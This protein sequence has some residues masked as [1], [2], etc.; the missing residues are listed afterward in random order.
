M[1]TENKNIL[2]DSANPKAEQLAISKPQPETWF[3]LNDVNEFAKVGTWL[4]LNNRLPEWSD[5]LRNL[6]EI[7][8]SVKLEN[9]QLK[10][11]IHPSDIPDF[12]ECVEKVLSGNCQT[13]EGHVRVLTQASKNINQLKYLIKGIVSNGTVIG[14]KGMAS[15]VQ[16]PIES[17]DFS[18]KSQEQFNVL[19]ATMRQGVIFHSPNSMVGKMNPA[20]YTILGLHPS[21][22]ND[23]SKLQFFLENGQKL[24]VRDYPFLQA[25]KTGKAILGRTLQVENSAGRSR[26]IRFDSFPVKA[27]EEIAAYSIIEDI[28]AG[29]TSYDLLKQSEERLANLFKQSG[30]GMAF[31]SFGGNLLD[32]NNTFSRI[33]GYS[34][35]EL[36]QMNLEHLTHPNDLQQIEFELNRSATGKITSFNLE[37][38]LIHKNKEICWVSLSASLITT[39]SGKPYYLI[40]QFQDITER[41]LSE[42]KIFESQQKFITAFYGA[43]VGMAISDLNGKIIDANDAICKLL[44]FKKQEI[45]GKGINKITYAEDS[46]KD[47]VQEQNL[48]N[49]KING[50][51]IQKRYTHKSGKVI[52]GL[53]SVNLIRDAEGLP[54]NCIIQIQDMTEQVLSGEAIQKERQKFQHIF[55]FASIGMALIDTMGKI[56]DAN[57]TLCLILGYS[58]K[59]LQLQDLTKLA[60]PED[61]AHLKSQL[62]ELS[63]EKLSRTTIEIR[64]IHKNNNLVHSI[65]SA[66]RIVEPND[67]GVYLLAQIQ[68]INELKATQIKRLETESKFKHVVE[69]AQIGISIW[70]GQT[71]TYR[72][73]AFERFFN[74][75]GAKGNFDLK[76][77]NSLAHAGTRNKILETQ[78]KLQKGSS[79]AQKFI[80]KFGTPHAY[81]TFELNAKS[82]LLEGKL[83]RIVLVNDL[84]DNLRLE[85]ELRISQKILDQ[86]Q[87]FTKTGNWRWIVGTNDFFLSKSVYSILGIK[88]Q[89]NKSSLDQFINAVHPEDKKEVADAIKRCML[90]GGTFQIEHRV[91]Q[92]NGQTKWM[93]ERGTTVR[94]TSGDVIELF[95]VIREIT[96]EKKI[97][98]ELN[99]SKEQYQLLA[100]SGQELISLHTTDGKFLYASPSL[101]TLLGVPLSK[102]PK[103]TKLS[104]LVHSDDLNSFSQLITSALNQPQKEFIGRFRYKHKIGHFIPCEQSI[105]ALISDP[106]QA[107]TIRSLIRN[108]EGQISFE[109]QLK[110]TNYQFEIALSALN[111]ASQAKENF[112]SVMSHEIRTPLNSVIGLSHLLKRRNPRE[113]QIEIVETLKNSADNLMHLVN[114]ILDYNKIRSGKLKIENI[115]F[116]LSAILRQLLAAYKPLAQ[117]KEINLTIQIDSEIPD[118]VK[119]DSTRLNQIFTNLITNA[120]KFT[121]EGF[122]KVSAALKSLT[123]NQCNVDFIIEDSG[124]GIPKEYHQA[125]F[126][127]FQQSDVDISRKFGGTGL[128]LSIVKSLTELMSG[129]IEITSEP[130]VGSTFIVT[131]PFELPEHN[132]LAL[133]LPAKK[134]PKITQAKSNLHILYVEDVDS[135]RFLLEQILN[136]YQLKCTSVSSGKAALKLTAIKKFDLILMDLQMPILD[137]YA[138]TRKIKNQPNGVNTTTPIVAFTAEAFSAELKLKTTSEGIVYV[139]SKPFDPEKLIEKII[140][141]SASKQSPNPEFS[142]QFYQNLFSENENKFNEIKTAIKS[143]FLRFQKKI[144]HAWKAKDQDLI[145]TESHRIRPIARNLSFFKLTSILDKLRDVEIENLDYKFNLDEAIALVSIL[146][147]KLDSQ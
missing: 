25:I 50:Y 98:L 143:D 103:N 56:L 71:L 12:E 135:N 129:V 14:L 43:S 146:L 41:V 37:K 93:E 133:E 44:G 13:C 104:D 110:E 116:K 15:V 128:G 97:Q 20:A 1:P 42:K 84:T 46:D 55:Q 22:D 5:G 109:N 64:F 77:I 100:E 16:R 75:A 99:Q 67:G 113:D 89:G 18:Q 132:K 53:L 17:L 76:T 66:G 30:V 96:Q 57:N 125:I 142:L 72:N 120:I 11:Y 139:I 92:K 40:A 4:E 137:G 86:A 45:I 88:K 121:K 81:R 108:I 138:T 36:H 59:E 70:Q 147:E 35:E 29:R 38:R 118:L 136:D 83:H 106:G 105:K 32:V 27:T 94:N 101:K 28:T 58:E 107:P 140:S 6:L 61:Q 123:G 122:V 79:I 62:T 3:E 8:G 39:A 24:P 131:I 80:G 69:S 130:G 141:I 52:H 73:Q 51:T 124:I 144:N 127:P 60:H 95:G 91:Q 21:D 33:T 63:K 111:E 10:N 114:D 7:P 48:L 145:R 47:D 34:I 87:K 134:T 90:I 19:L 49:G 31:I 78:K 54:L 115:E 23:L 2:N 117:E 85:N 9:P 65:F 26:W 112:L 82:I 119:G 126:E 68:D 74:Q 102:L